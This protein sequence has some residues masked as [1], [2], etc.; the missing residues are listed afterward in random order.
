MKKALK[1]LA[2]SI[3]VV[4]LFAGISMA[5]TI[6]TRP[7]YT[8][9]G[10]L[11]S[12]QGIM[13]GIGSSIDVRADQEDYAIFTNQSAGSNA[14][15]VASLSWNAT[16]FPFEFGIYEYGNITNQVAVFKDSTDGTGASN[17]GDYTTINFDAGSGTIYSEF[18]DAGTIGSTVIGSTTDWMDSFGFYFSWDAGNNIYYSEDSL[19]GTGAS[20]LSFLGKGEDVTIGGLTANDAN[21]RYVAMEGWGGTLDF[22]DIVVQLESVVPVP[23]PATLLLL[24]FGLVGLAGA[25]RKFKK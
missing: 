10:T 1:L 21:H 5:D 24:G 4:F 17:P 19:N 2:I 22:N 18:H 7:V 12:L 3:A 16:G 6:N 8:S 25:S 15:Y 9:G 20:F 23:E 11:D 13:T 14:A